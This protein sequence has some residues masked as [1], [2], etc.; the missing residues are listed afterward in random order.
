MKREP[1]K[2]STILLNIISGFTNPQ[3]A[4]I[5]KKRFHENGKPSNYF[6]S[7]AD[8]H[9]IPRGHCLPFHMPP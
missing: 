7:T 5:D 1:G 6:L 3:L 4:H 9:F 2:K 8:T